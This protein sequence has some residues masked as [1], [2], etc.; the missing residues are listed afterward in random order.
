MTPE[1]SQLLGPYL[2]LQSSIFQVI[3]EAR[4]GDYV[5][6]FEALVHRRNAQ[7]V[8]ILYFRWL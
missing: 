7:D 4:I 2:V 5:R 8:A 3:V 6:R 1:I